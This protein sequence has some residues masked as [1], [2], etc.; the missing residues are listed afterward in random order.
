M[1]GMNN[2]VLQEILTKVIDYVATIVELNFI[3]VIT[4]LLLLFDV[5]IKCD[6]F[7]IAFCADWFSL[8]ENNTVMLLISHI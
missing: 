4:K 3:F 8:M 6:I 5:Y 2:W 1:E 7:G